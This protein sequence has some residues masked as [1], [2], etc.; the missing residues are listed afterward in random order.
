MIPR[1]PSVVALPCFQNVNISNFPKPLG[2][3]ND[4]LRAVKCGNRTLVTAKDLKAS[5]DPWPS[6]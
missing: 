4:E 6:R 5:M 2:I 1:P 3:R